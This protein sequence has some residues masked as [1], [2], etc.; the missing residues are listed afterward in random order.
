MSLSKGINIALN[1]PISLIHIFK[2]KKGIILHCERSEVP[3]KFLEI[4]PTC[5]KSSPVV[6]CVKPVVREEISGK[7]RPFK[8]LFFLLLLYSVHIVVNGAIEKVEFSSIGM[9]HK[10]SRSIIKEFIVYVGKLPGEIHTRSDHYL[11]SLVMT[12]ISVE[13]PQKDERIGLDLLEI[14][15]KLFLHLGFSSVCSPLLH[16]TRGTVK[17]V[18]YMCEDTMIRLD[19]PFDPFKLRFPYE[20]KHFLSLPIS[21]IFIINSSKTYAFESHSGKQLHSCA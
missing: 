19:S 21:L 11:I 4:R 14:S 2:G 16:P 6:S 7:D 9:V 17:L 8:L 1:L 13:A 10:H 20:F 18:H 5:V 3:D 15:V 12:G